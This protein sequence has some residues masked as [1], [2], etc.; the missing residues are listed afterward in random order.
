V[1]VQRSTGAHGR[2]RR[3]W[4]RADAGGGLPGLSCLRRAAGPVGSWPGTD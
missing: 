4:R 1:R 3:G 2:Q